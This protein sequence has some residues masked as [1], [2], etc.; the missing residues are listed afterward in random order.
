M[1]IVSQCNSSSGCER[2]WSTF[3]LVHTKL[4]NKLSY[5]KLMKL[6]YVHYNIKLYIQ[7]FEADFES[8][9]EKETDPYSLMMDAAVFD[10]SNPIMDWLCH[11]RSESTPVL[12]E[13]DFEADDW[14]CPGGFLIDQLQMDMTEVTAFKRKLFFGR[15]GGKKKGKV[16][17]EEDEYE[18]LF[19][20]NSDSDSPHGSPEYA[21]SQDSSSASSDDE[22]D[23]EMF[24]QIN[25]KHL[26]F[27]IY[28]E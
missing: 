3:A 17:I 15:N 12:D 8:L 2:N 18:D 10:E 16:Q 6:V 1:R 25:Y 7:Q 14:A 22:G 13:Y 20:D 19:E 26:R 4:R 24:V 28:C 23:C 21:E 9:K 11:S 5:D 27:L